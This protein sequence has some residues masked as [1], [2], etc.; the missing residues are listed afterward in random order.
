M[1]DRLRKT[2]GSFIEKVSNE[3][4]TG[5]K[6][7]SILTELRLSLIE[8]DVAVSVAE[9]VSE[10]LSRELVGIRVGRLGDRKGLV[11]TALRRT[12][13]EILIPAGQVNLIAAAEE[14]RKEHRSIIVVFVGINGTGKT[15]TLGKVTRL[16]QKN[17]FSVVLACSDT[18]RA[19]AIE[20]LEIHAKRLAVRII[21]HEYGSDAA[22]VAFDAI[23]FAKAH[24]INAVLIDTAG[25][26]ETNRNLMEEMR[27]IVRVTNPDLV[28]FVGDALA[29]NDAAV[30]AEEFSKFVPLSASILTKMDADAKGGSAISVSYITKR[31]VILMGTGQ[32]YESLVPFEPQKYVDM[33]LERID[34]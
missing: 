5:D 33:L 28:V 29:G 14:A 25:R 19:G 3:E 18:Y 9:K 7:S 32:D 10:D 20:Q 12:L 2:F 16:L 1:F 27:K 17:G 22:S 6:L 4:I 21:K 8:N 30:Q 26:M 23:A 13:A 31:P 11:T 34:S 24:G 15:T